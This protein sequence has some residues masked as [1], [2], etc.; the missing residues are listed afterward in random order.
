MALH[1]AERGVIAFAVALATIGVA[2]TTCL[3]L[4]QP[5]PVWLLGVGALCGLVAAWRRRGGQSVAVDHAPRWLSLLTIAVMAVA[6]GIVAFGA[7]ATPSRHWDGAVAWDL[8]AAVLAAHAHLEQPFFRDDA[9]YSHSRDYPL[10][11]P[12]LL[13]LLEGLGVAGRCLFPLVFT[14]LLLAVQVAARSVHGAVRS[15]WFVI[16]ATLT[17]MFLAPT[18]GGFDS[19]YADGLMAAA[20]AITALGFVQRSSALLV[21]GAIV[22]AMAKPEGT[23]YAATLVV[24]VWLHGSRASVVAVGVGA[25]IGGALA[26]A[27]QQDLVHG[28]RSSMVWPAASGALVA[29]AALVLADARL[30]ARGGGQRARWLLLA[31]A[32]VPLSLLLAWLPRTGSL[33]SHFAD[34]ERFWQRLHHLPRV[35]L[36]IVEWAWFSGRFGLAFVLPVLFLMAKA[37]RTTGNAATRGLGIWLLLAVPVSFAP[38]LLSPIDDV[39]GHLRSALPRMLL[40]WCGAVWV[41]SAVQPW[42]TVGTQTNNGDPHSGVAA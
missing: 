12:L 37:P 25:A 7:L 5:A 10:L 15:S 11:Q 9:V 4:H 23:A 28:G 22:I 29:T 3:L 41:W 21:A 18:S 40:Q 42:P 6:I 34:G 35:A 27:L 30:R 24:A 16:A 14:M 13:A 38:F 19:G 31:L 39:E 2:G 17:P 32:I 1:L 26:L 36:A 20:I 33:G 8:K